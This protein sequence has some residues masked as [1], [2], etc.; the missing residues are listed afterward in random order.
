MVRETETRAMAWIQGF[1]WQ[2]TG[3]RYL[4]KTYIDTDRYGRVCEL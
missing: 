3:T 1:L 2:P 4:I